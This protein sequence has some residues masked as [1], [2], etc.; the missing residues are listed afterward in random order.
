VHPTHRGRGI[1]SILLRRAEEFLAWCGCTSVSLS[2][3]A[4]GYFL[5]G[6]DLERHADAL[7]FLLRRGYSEIYRPVAMEAPLWRLS[8]PQWIADRE[9]EHLAQGLTYEPYSPDLTLPLLRFT[10]AWFPGDWVRVVRQ[11]MSQIVQGAPRERLSIAVEREG[12][13]AR[14]L[15]F[16]HF[17]NERFGPIGV[18]DSERG[19]GIGQILM[20]KTLLA[21]R[22]AGFRTSWFL[23]SDDRT[24]TRLYNSAGFREVRRF[25]LLRKEF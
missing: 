4:P 3:Y 14:V 12:G 17:E 2:P 10:E 6:V 22:R 15:G 18:A 1:G 9:P 25:A 13:D 7:S 19:R 11:A 5:P 8:M 16:S 20:F 23:W 21:Q 24:A